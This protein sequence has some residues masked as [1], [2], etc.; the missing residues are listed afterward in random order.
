[1]F[2]DFARLAPERFYKSVWLRPDYEF[3]MGWLKM[4]EKE[5]LDNAM[6]KSRLSSQG[7]DFILLNPLQFLALPIP[8]PASHFD[9]RRLDTR[10]PMITILFVLIMILIS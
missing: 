1:M 10:G 4:P 9:R 7:F 6:G 2:G 5:I 8:N 3:V